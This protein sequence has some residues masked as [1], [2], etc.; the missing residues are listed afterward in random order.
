MLFE[1]IESTPPFVS[2]LS[3]SEL[4][5]T[6][7]SLPYP[8]SSFSISLFLIFTLL[9]ELPNN[10][11]RKSLLVL[12]LSAFESSIFTKSLPEPVFKLSIVEPYTLTVSLPFLVLIDC[13]LELY[14]EILVFSLLLAIFAPFAL[15]TNTSPVSLFSNT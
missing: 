11:Q 2:R 15:T 3:T 6:T 10:P 1:D 12:T 8:V 5:K 9:F 13:I 4:L 14:I 7:V